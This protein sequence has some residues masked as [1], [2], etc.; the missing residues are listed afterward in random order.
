MYIEEIRYTHE[1]VNI[2]NV[3][4][5]LPVLHTA[6]E[7]YQTCKRSDLMAGELWLQ[8]SSFLLP[9]SSSEF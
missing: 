1:A 3:P 7:P 6:E 2:H 9:Q 5:L 4:T 8:L